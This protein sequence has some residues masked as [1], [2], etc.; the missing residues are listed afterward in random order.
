[1]NSKHGRNSALRIYSRFVP[2][3]YFDNHSTTQLDPEALEAMLPFL[4]DQFANAGSITHEAGRQVSQRVEDARAQ[5]ASLLGAINDELVFTSG[6][7]ESNNLALFGTCLHPRQKRRKV[8][9]VAT[10]HKAILG[11]LDRLSRHGFEVV[12]LPVGKNK[13]PDAGVV[14]LQR[15]EDEVDENTALVSVMLANNEIGVVQPLRQ[16]ADICH[17]VGCYLHTDATQAVGRMV[18]DVDAL[19]VD[20]LSFSAHKFY[21]PKGTGGLFV[22]R[23]NR[24]VKLQ[25]QIVGGGQQNNFRSGTL[26]PAGIVAMATALTCC[27]RNNQWLGNEN[28]AEDIE[29]KR[30][31]Q[32]TSDLYH[33]ISDGTPGLV[34]NGPPLPD[35]NADMNA[36]RRLPGN[37]NCSF[38]PVEGQSLMLA[39]PDLAVSSGSACTSAEPGASHVLRQIG[40]SEE[41]ARSS[42]R[43]GLGRFNTAE[44]VEQAAQWIIDGAAKLRCLI[45]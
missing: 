31:A 3:I 33:R 19:D 6:A 42:L 40:L 11:P 17:R 18:V 10:E 14:D 27:H 13:T 43:F 23:R 9:S 7:T 21:G 22:R 44:E 16:I 26:N 5:T 39:A 37:L 30:V 45:P 25:G 28:S 4:R 20:L 24:K 15:L 12:L 29:W 32:L 41:Q 8:V 34:L 2:L 38:Y 36:T 35:P 1:M